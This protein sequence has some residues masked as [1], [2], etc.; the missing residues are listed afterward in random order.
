M[1]APS[2]H[3]Y[4]KAST[5]QGCHQ[6]EWK[7]WQDSHHGWAMREASPRSVLGDF[8]DATF[9]DTAAGIHARFFR[10]DGQYYVNTEGADGKRADFRILYTFGV[11]PLQQYLV[12]FPGG[13]LQ[14]LT[15]AWDS[16]PKQKGGQRWYSLY[17]GQH[18]ALGDPLRW[19]GHS[20]NWNGM[21]ADCHS[22][23]LLKNYDDQT[24]S[25]ATTWK[26]INV[27]C[28][29]CHG[30]G[31]AHVDWAR[32]EATQGKH[33]ESYP[34]AKQMK[35]DVDFA[36]MSSHGIVDQCARCHSRRQSLGVGPQT[37]KPLLDAMLPAT[38]QPDLYFPDGQKLGEV[39][40]YGSFAQSK[41]YQQG[42]TC[43]DCHN[44]HTAKVKIQDNGL[45]TQCHNPHPPKRFPGLWAKNYDTPEHT[46]HKPGT[47]GSQCIDCH[48]PA[49]TYMGVDLRRDHFFRIP[50]PDLDTK[51]A[52]PDTCTGCHKDKKP[53]WAAN[54]I[55]QW[56]T[57][58]EH[59]PG[60]GVTLLAARNGRP[61]AMNKL[62]ALLV[63]RSMP[64]IARATA[65]EDLGNLGPP[66][67]PSLATALHDPSAL[68]RAYTIPAFSA[69]P[70][71]RRIKRLLPLLDDPAQA[72]RDAAV[73][74][75]AGVSLS[76]LPKARQ[77]SFQVQLKDYERRLRANAD[78][79]GNRLNLAVL[80]QRE[81]RQQEALVQYRM[82]L[83]IDPYFSPARVNLVLLDNQSGHASEAEELLRDGVALKGLPA[84]D[85]GHL[86]YLLSLLL[87]PQGHKDQALHWLEQAAQALPDQPR[88]RYN[89]GLLLL[90]MGRRAQAQKILEAGLAS[91]K[92]NPDLLYALIYLHA[93]A[94]EKG[95][96]LQYLKRLEHAAPDDQRLPLLR[97]E[98]R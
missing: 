50:R 34:S 6:E 76:D 64:V 25:F 79:A 86:A 92:D 85:R 2:L 62:S 12:A 73:S 82:A 21:C 24:D 97:Q 7:Q 32:E 43:L 75:M 58:P 65:A 69:E 53:D 36:T 3:G 96:A 81:G 9:N 93:S 31:Q 44:P 61:D 88:I 98:L 56:V 71:A 17:P 11:F 74:A 90:Q 18:F 4:A 77:V 1:L 95:E 22:T 67:L 28:Q 80:L 48:M 39:Y 27:G 33:D 10:R 26:E 70:A 8:N 30:S 23:D 19:T 46:H 89:Q 41:M 38:L 59:P 29:S 63:N 78:F 83:K 87:V 42:V 13:R 15:I 37:G 40:V 55:K 47:S 91:S 20:H 60:Y 35:L 5:C 52:S 49:R 68:V 14:S 84:T 72:V 57:Y 66:A 54:V 16:R 45:C 51:T 94:G